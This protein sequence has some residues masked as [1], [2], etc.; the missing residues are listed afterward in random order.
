[1]Y[2]QVS[3]LDKSKMDWQDFK[4]TDKDIQEELEAHARSDKQYLDKKV[5]TCVTFIAPHH[6]CSNMWTDLLKLRLLCA[7]C[8]I[9]AVH[10]CGQVLQAAC[11]R[12]LLGRLI[13]WHSTSTCQNHTTVLQALA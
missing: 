2:V 4:K 7:C 6:V 9:G 3:V 5:G 12:L 1:M 11:H 8:W 13:L 10:G